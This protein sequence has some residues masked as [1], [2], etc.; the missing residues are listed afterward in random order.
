MKTKVLALTLLAGCSAAVSAAL[1][2]QEA[3]VSIPRDF[4]A[5]PL[6]R[7][8]NGFVLAYDFHMAKV[9]EYDHTG[10]T[11][12]ALSL[13]TPDA[14]DIHITDMAAAAD[15]TV[16][17]S[18]SVLD[19][20]GRDPVIFWITPAG[21]VA[22]IVRTA[23]FSA[24]R[25]VF[26]SDGSLWAAGRTY[27]RQ[28]AD[29]STDPQYDVLRRYDSQGRFEGSAVPNTTFT[30][31]PQN[32][33]LYSFLMSGPNRIGFLSLDGKEY[34]EVSLSG[35][36]LGDWKINSKLPFG[37]GDVGGVALTPSGALFLSLAPH[38]TLDAPYEGPPLY[39]L[40]KASGTLRPVE[41]S[42]TTPVTKPTVLLGCDRGKLVFYSKPPA[43]VS[44]FAVQ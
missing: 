31:A 6:P 10:K 12:F 32:P 11:L 21:A 18:A 27:R 19:G 5:Q 23:P 29:F 44:W 40:D 39:Q 14:T 24:S 41:L 28:G 30:A 2:K 8:G 34:V 13:S 25:V 26:S 3:T 4:T 7:F 37:V 17:V 9:W 22:R 43:S 33:A 35:K 15:G 38:P 1:V 42:A 16:A 36:V 20:D